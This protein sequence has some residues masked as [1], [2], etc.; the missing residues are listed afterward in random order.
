MC[1]GC[2]TALVQAPRI[3]P[4]DQVAGTSHHQ[5]HAPVRSCGQPPSLCHHTH[6][7]PPSFLRDFLRDVLSNDTLTHIH[8]FLHRLQQARSGSDSSQLMCHSDC[9]GREGV[10]PPPALGLRATIHVPVLL[11]RSFS[12]TTQRHTHTQSPQQARSSSA[13]TQ[14]CSNSQPLLRLLVQD[15]GRLAI[16]KHP[17][18]LPRTHAHTRHSRTPTHTHTC[19][20]TGANARFLDSRSG[21][22]RLSYSQGGAVPRWHKLRHLRRTQ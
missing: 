9:P 12:R 5:K 22:M 1:R 11:T 7:C 13:S 18:S 15:G 20:P 17:Q 3:G 6:I 8:P 19:T 21:H 10:S 4:S 16:P 2:S 14:L